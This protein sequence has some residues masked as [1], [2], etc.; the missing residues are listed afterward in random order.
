MKAMFSSKMLVNFFKTTYDHILD[1]SS[2]K[3]RIPPP[4]TTTI[5]LCLI[6]NGLTHSDLMQLSIHHKLIMGYSVQQFVFFF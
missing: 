2:V 5:V 4:T 3:V 1:D 6:K